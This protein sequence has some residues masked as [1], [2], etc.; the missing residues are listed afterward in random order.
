MKVGYAQFKPSFGKNKENLEHALEFLEE[1]IKI[2]GKLMVLP[3][4]FNSGYVFEKKDELEEYAEDITDG[5]TSKRLIDFAKSKNIF[6]VAGICEKHQKAFF[7]SSV[8]IGP[9][10]LIG[11]YRKTH[12]FFRE[13]LWFTPG[14]ENF[15]VYD[16]S[17]VRVGMMIC[18]DWFFPEVIRIL[19]LKGA[20]VI[21]H[22][23]NLVLPY[24]QKALL[25]A[26]VQN[27]VFI[28]TANRV[29][30]ERGMH[31][32]GLSQIVDPNMRILTKSSRSKQNVR[33]VEIDPNVALNKRINE[34]N[35]VFEDRRVDLY[36][37]I[38][39]K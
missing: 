35:N 26:A 6:I 9:K 10:G 18:F 36:K 34:F 16:V 19:S 14:K 17:G 29:G 15:E 5:K 28:I 20:Q 3:E 31:F 11:V 37:S 32:T 8:L 21:C 23:A 1:G 12:L 22:P 38:L 27:H 33:I 4:L 2:G 39:Y 7:N 30:V 13:K 25:G 24:C